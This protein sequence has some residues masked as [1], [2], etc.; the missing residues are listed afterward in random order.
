V[1]TH[2]VTKGNMRDKKKTRVHDCKRGKDTQMKI[3]LSAYHPN[4]HSKAEDNTSNSNKE[5]FDNVEP[6]AAQLYGC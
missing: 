1:K 6:N 2:T 4:P 5:D 3:E